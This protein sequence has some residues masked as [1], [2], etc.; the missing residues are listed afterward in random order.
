[1]FTQSGRVIGLQYSFGKRQRGCTRATCYWLHQFL[2]MA[3]NA[4]ILLKVSSF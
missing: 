3:N 4:W 2:T 1:M